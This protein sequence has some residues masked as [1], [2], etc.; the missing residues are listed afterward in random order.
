MISRRFVLRA[1][2]A[3]S[4][5]LV[6]SVATPV[7]ATAEPYRSELPLGRPGLDETRATAQLAP[8]VTHT[9]IVRGEASKHDGYI[10]DVAFLPSREAAT[11][12]VRQLRSVGFQARA[13]QIDE[14][15]PDDPQ[16]G[17]LGYL[18]RAGK[19]SSQAEAT[20]LRDRLA[21]AGYTGLRVVFSGEDGGRTTGPWVVNVLDIS[22]GPF[23]GQVKPAL[24]TGVVP[25]LER[26][27]GIA[28]RTGSLAAINGGYFVIGA[29]DGT[30]GDLAGISVLDGGLVSEAVNGRT[31]L[32]LPAGDGTGASVA[33]LSTRQ[34]AVA[35]DGGRREI[36]GLN[37]KPGL[38]RGC[39]GTGGD[40]PTEA[41]KHDFTCVDA[42]ELILFTPSFGPTSEPGDGTE[43]VLDLT[44]TVVE[45]RSPRG[46]VIPAGGSVLAG[47]GEGAEWLLAHARPGAGIQVGTEVQADGAPLAPAGLGVV[48]GGPRLL[49]SGAVE[50][51]AAAEGFSWQERPEFYY[52][53]GVRRN[54]RTLAGVTAH[55]HLLLVTIEGRQPGYSVGT[56]FLESAMVMRALGAIDAVNLDGGGSTA[57]AI[58]NDLVSRPSD[59]AGERP[60][61]DAIVVQGG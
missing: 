52:R 57:M 31:S 2:A 42:S 28:A 8:G 49:R 60:I 35:S 22:P 3:L 55:G 58:G 29:A 51:T 18:V 7:V 24:A 32:L 46:G 16:V 26:L 59:A 15:A 25:G 38:V 23:A 14:R 34:S 21:A 36:D 17:P 56:S 33:A 61:A 37:R 13:E 1:I 50:I 9:R 39:G 5:L 53:F 40:L 20:Q 10:V 41:P 47:T 11:D 12:L 54:P 45:L 43:A 27:S 6:S 4:I 48:N 30:P 44:G 19:P